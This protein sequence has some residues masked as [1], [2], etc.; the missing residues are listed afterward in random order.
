MFLI[1]L[2][3]LI[4]WQIHVWRSCCERSCCR[5]Q[6]LPGCQ[7]SLGQKSFSTLADDYS[8]LTPHPSTA[9][10]CNT[11]AAATGRCSRTVELMSSGSRRP[12]VP[13]SAGA[14]HTPAPS[15]AHSCLSTGSP[16]GS[17]RATQDD[18]QKGLQS[19]SHNSLHKGL[20]SHN[21]IMSKSR[22]GGGADGRMRAGLR[23]RREGLSHKRRLFV[24]AL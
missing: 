2:I 18:T 14:R 5:N 1:C 3:L 16:A 7:T 8:Q 24:L 11:S 20:Q 21:S 12:V 10:N 23:L 6:T 17:S 15:D 9:P 22:L 19:A 4:Y 13:L